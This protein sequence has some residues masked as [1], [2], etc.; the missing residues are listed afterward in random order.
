MGYFET[1]KAD[2]ENLIATISKEKAAFEQVLKSEVVS[3]EDKI[4]W[5]EKLKEGVQ[6]MAK[7]RQVGFPWLAE[8]Y[9][10]LFKMRDE[11]LVK[12]LKNKKHAA[13]QASEVVREQGR[14]R[15]E[16]VKEA[17]IA[18]YLVQYYESMAPFLLDFKEE[19]DVPTEED[20]KLLEEYSVEEKQDEV[21]S[22]LAKEEYRKLPSVE[23]NQ[24]ALDRFWKRP[25]SK[26]LIGRLYERYVGY[27]YEEQGYNVDYIGIFRGFEDLGRDLICKKGNEFIIIQCKN[28]AQ[29]RTIYEKHIFQFFG[30]VFQ[31]KDENPDRLVKSIFYTATSL[32]DLARRFAKEL[33]IGLMENFKLDQQYPCI[34][35]NISKVD[36][37]KIYHLPFDQQYD[38]TKI[39]VKRGEF[40]CKTAKEAEDK[41]FRRAFRYKGLSKSK[42]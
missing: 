30:T 39:E 15:R 11:V 12:Y 21:I 20:R 17:K 29:F 13:I 5:F 22:F 14:L 4:S 40:Y 18:Q 36:G 23:R 16:A 9:K 35:C 42:T 3:L 41:G 32:S 2:L 26:W 37:T 24:M 38:K 27:L 25:K 1:K 31:Y 8:A 19:V 7:E 10:E 6:Q 28:W 33:G 34:K